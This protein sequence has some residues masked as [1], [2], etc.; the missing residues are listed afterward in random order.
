MTSRWNG[1]M[2]KDVGDRVDDVVRIV[3]L[4]IFY[5]HHPRQVDLYH[6]PIRLEVHRF[7][8]REG[9]VLHRRW[10]TRDNLPMTT[11]MTPFAL[12]DINKTAA[13]LG[14]FI[15]EHVFEAMRVAVRESDVIVRETYDVAIKYFQSLKVGL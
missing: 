11:E 1:T 6:H 10:K 13:E 14:D 9:D 4:K 3:E 5:S 7:R 2:M 8:P 15:S 12:S